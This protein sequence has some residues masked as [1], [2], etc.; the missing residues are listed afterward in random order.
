MSGRRV[1]FVLEKDLE[2]KLRKIQAKMI[3]K[4]NQ[5]VSFT[6]IL[7]YTLKRCLKNIRV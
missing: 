7:N 5:E 1:T 4:T 3:K 2:G 6:N